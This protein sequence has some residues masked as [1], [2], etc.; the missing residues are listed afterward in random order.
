MWPFLP[1]LVNCVICHQMLHILYQKSS[2]LIFMIIS[3]SRTFVRYLWLLAIWPN[4]PFNAYYITLPHLLSCYRVN[5]AKKCNYLGFGCTSRD[6]EMLHNGL[7]RWL[8]K[9]ILVSS[10]VWVSYLLIDTGCVWT[11]QK[12]CTQEYEIELYVNTFWFGLVEE[13][14]IELIDHSG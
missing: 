12:V 6:I 5:V 2:F 3:I 4:N 7:F 9:L 10:F 8:E 11:S 1:S 14:T 13:E